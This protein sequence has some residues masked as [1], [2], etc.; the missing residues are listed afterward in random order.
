VITTVLTEIKTHPLFSFDVFLE[1]EQILALIAV[2]HFE[3]PV[4]GWI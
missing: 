3:C 4:R 2:G 1:N